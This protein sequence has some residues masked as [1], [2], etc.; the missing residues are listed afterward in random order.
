MFVDLS[1]KERRNLILALQRI[2]LRYEKFLSVEYRDCMDNTMRSE[3]ETKL[4]EFRELELKLIG[5]II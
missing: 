5:T 2:E 4:K 3:F 1:L